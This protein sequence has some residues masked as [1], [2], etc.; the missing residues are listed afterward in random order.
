MITYTISVFYLED[1]LRIGA[2]NNI[3]FYFLP[4]IPGMSRTRPCKNVNLH[5]RKKINFVFLALVK[6][7]INGQNTIIVIKL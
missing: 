5:M 3:F 1:E 6:P 7:Q 2:G 4:K